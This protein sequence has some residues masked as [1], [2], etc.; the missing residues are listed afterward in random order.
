MTDDFARV[1][2]QSAHRIT[3]PVSV[4]ALEMVG[5]GPST[6]LLD[7]AAGAGALSVPAAEKGAR[8]VATDVAP[9]MVR[10]LAERLR[11]FPGCEAREMDGEALGFG[12]Q[13]FDAAFSIFGVML[14]SDWRRGLREQARVLRT[15]GKGCVATWR[16]PPGGGPFVL[17]ASALRSIFPDRPSPAS[18]EGM[19]VLSDPG[20][21]EA[22][23]RAGGFDQVEVRELQGTWKGPAGDAYFQETEA[24]HRYMRP[25]AALDEAGRA[26]VKSKIRLLLDE[27]TV[28]EA[29]ELPSAVLV[30]IGTR[31]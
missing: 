16:D 5:I 18:P 10:R 19:A 25:Y 9:G 24:L 14:F 6:R 28:R 8:V 12:D 30:G 26:R 7:I 20:Q 11:T 2:E 27:H 17:M 1:Y 22:E 23:M 15:G 13:S 4:A 31:A 29:V 3:E 21:L